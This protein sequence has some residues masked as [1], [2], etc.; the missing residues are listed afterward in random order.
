MAPIQTEITFNRSALIIRDRVKERKRKDG[1]KGNG[2][3]PFY[4]DFMGI[5]TVAHYLPV[6]NETINLNYGGKGYVYITR[7]KLMEFESE[8]KSINIQ[9][10]SIHDRFITRLFT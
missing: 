8:G 6:F 7:Y 2:T 3:L 4:R 1:G 10:Y 5:N 9:T